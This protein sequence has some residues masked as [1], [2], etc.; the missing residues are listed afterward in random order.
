MEQTYDFREWQNTFNQ[1]LRNAQT[2]TDEVNDYLLD[3]FKSCF[4]TK[5]FGTT[6]WKP[7][8]WNED[9]LVESGELK[10]SI[11]T[12]S[13]SI[14]EIHIESGL[15]Y[16]AIHNYGGTIRVTDKMIAF[17]WAKYKQTG[18][19]QWK[20]MALTKKSFIIMPQRQFMGTNPEI[21]NQVKNIIFDVLN[22][23]LKQ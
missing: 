23:K 11:K 22:R 6:Q 7:S 3:Y 1:I 16:S 9:T 19:E 21:E 5:S 20:N 4:D 8:V 17:F 18:K 14:S 15:A 13:K 12:I 2:I 10:R